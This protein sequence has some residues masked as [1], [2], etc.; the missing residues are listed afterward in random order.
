[1]HIAELSET[2]QFKTARCP[3]R[4]ARGSLLYLIQT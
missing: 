2:E 3:F 4:A 1:M